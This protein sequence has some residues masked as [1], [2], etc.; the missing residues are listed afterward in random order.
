MKIRKRKFKLSS[1]TMMIKETTKTCD[2]DKLTT[3]IDVSAG[4]GQ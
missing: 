3:E 2:N 4:Q 1:M